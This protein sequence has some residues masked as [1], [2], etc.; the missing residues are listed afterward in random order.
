MLQQHRLDAMFQ[1]QHRLLLPIY[2]A[3][4]L[5]SDAAAAWQHACQVQQELLLLAATNITW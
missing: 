4:G 3:T 2:A 5:S 1:P